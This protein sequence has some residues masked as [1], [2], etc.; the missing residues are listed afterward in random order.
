MPS[1]RLQLVQQLQDLRLD[2]D[3]EVRRRLVGKDE[4]RVAKQ[5]ARDADALL[6]AAAELV[7][8]LPEPRQ[9]VGDADKMQQLRDARPRLA[10]ADLL[11]PR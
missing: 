7:R 3:V 2:G 6:H 4:R 11:V 5:R 10:A 9:R 1:R 8:E